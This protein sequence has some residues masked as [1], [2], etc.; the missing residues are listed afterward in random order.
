MKLRVSRIAIAVLSLALAT[1]AAQQTSSSAGTASQTVPPLIQFAN[2]ATD[3]GGNTLSGVASITFSLY[4]S[5]QGG[6]PLWSE[7]QNNV[8]LDST[9]HYS[10]ELGITKQNGVPT[11]LFTNGEARW[12]GVQIAGQAEQARVL[13]LSVPYA[14][15][16]GDAA[17]IGGLPPSAFV[18]A[19]AQ[20]GTAAAYTTDSATRQ[21]VSS[22]T[23]SDVTTS[24]GT[25]NYLPL[26]D[27]ASDITNSVV[28]QSG[29]GSTAKIGINNA[30]PA[31][32]LDVKGAGTI[33]GTLSVLGSLALPATGTATATAGKNSEPLSLTASA[34]SS[35]TSATVNQTFRWQAE[36][37]GNDTSTPSGTLNLLF[38]EGTAAPEETGLHIANNGQITFAAGQTFPGTGDGTITGVTTASGS[39]LAGG[40]SSGT[41]NLSLTNACAANQVLQWNGTS[42][43][44]SSAGTGTVTSV[45]SGTGL[46]GGPITGSGTLSINTSVVPQLN[47]TNVF[48]GNQTVNGNLSATG[49]VTGSSYQIGSNL[50][51]FG[52][53]AN[54]NAFF[55]FAGNSTM[56]G[57]A[58]TAT[59]YQALFSDTTGTG[60]TA[61]GTLAL[62]SNTGDSSGDGSANTASGYA[63]LYSNTTGNSNTASGESALYAN[64]TGGGNTA[65]GS[66]ALY[67][68]TT[69]SNNTTSG[70]DALEQNT[71]GSNNTA[72]GYQALF[73]SAGSGNTGLGFNA[74][75]NTGAGSNNTAVGSNAGGGNT[76]GSSNT[77]IGYYAGTDA[78]T[79]S[80]TNA[81]AIGAYADVAQSN[82][83]VLGGI[84]GVNGATANTNVGIGTTVPAYALDVYGTGHFTQAVTFGSP[85]NFASGQTF[86]G[87]GTG[88]ITGVTANTGLTGGGTSGTVSL[89]LASNACASGSALTALPF[90]CSA[91]ATNGT[92][93]FGGSQTVD[94]SSSSIAIAGNQTA[95]TGTTYGV[96]G[97][98]VSTSGYGVY[99]EDYATSGANFG[100]FGASQS[101]SGT[102]VYGAAYPTSGTTIG[103][104]GLSQSASGYAVYGYNTGGGY[105]VYSAGNMGATGSIAAG[106][107]VSGVNVIATG[108]VTGGSVIATGTVQGGVVNAT[109]SFDL[110]GVF[111]ASGSSYPSYNAFLGFA[112]NT[113]M[114]GGYNTASGY[115][116]LAANISGGYN[117]ATGEQALSSDT[118]GSNNTAS[119]YEALYSNTGDSSGDGSGNAATGYEA[120]YYN[121]TG[122]YNTASGYQALYANTTASY[123]TASGYQ[124]LYANTTG[125]SSA[126]TG[127]LA[128]TANTTGAYNAAFGNQSLRQNT[129]GSYNVGLGAYGGQT[130]DGNPLT[131]SND[132][133]VGAGSAFG[134]DAITNA[135]AIGSNAVVSES[136]ALVLGCIAGLNSCGGAV[137]VGIGTATPTNI[138]TIAQ[139]AGD[140]IASGWTTYSSRR[141]KTNIHAL[142]NALGKVEQLRGVS[143]DLKDSGKHEIGVIAEEVGKV[144]PEVV[145]YEENGEDAR[146]VDYSRLTALLI[147]AVKQQQREISTQQQQM[148]AQQ[149]QIRGQQSQI[150]RLTDKVSVLETALRTAGQAEKSPATV[151][152]S[153]VTE[154]AVQ[155][156]PKN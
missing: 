131:G 144:I 111:F 88:T 123:S 5:Q 38:A 103:V 74:L 134:S 41:L 98:S 145:T 104:Y 65:S 141:W 79:P 72:S 82:S 12:L 54:G 63:A 99:G 14:L 80:L 29:T 9:G 146:G 27:A 124:A 118:T 152:L 33:R 133:A 68:N 24:G 92:N 87:T 53:Y 37:A 42:W 19:A 32:T 1:A 142:Q 155:T 76:S 50:F 15:K 97:T 143:Y 36:P 125:H 115:S 31:T 136:N 30:T 48:T 22:A 23:S 4:G 28:F 138:F 45:N 148:A 78:S 100:V 43:A 61:T 56:S 62:Y 139:G 39:G 107:N 150:A 129:T 114:T 69:G 26:W 13:L 112:G 90:T 153:A 121:T 3:E 89:A 70:Y 81:T 156:L 17:T 94:E 57:I 86:P 52:S 21:S 120:L 77:L 106:G 85:V 128:L 25:V 34:F 71:T 35:S 137:N 55:G 132:T 49:V 16:A 10:V 149:R 64:T 126:A 154:A 46:T 101:T 91:F 7:T 58:N 18:L 113:T 11:T 110:G 151:R 66:A 84:N 116:A 51:A 119:G 130:T 105:G 75:Y 40:G 67:A 47:A 93:A 60:N 108:A 20:S 96:M 109:T 117:T 6:E 44:C 73:H 147:E 95:S 122:N 8:Q 127:A 140:A 102:G 2:V 59:G 83:L 135:T